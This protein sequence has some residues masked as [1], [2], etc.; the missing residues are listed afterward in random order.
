METKFWTEDSHK[1]LETATDMPRYNR[2]LVSHFVDYFGKNI[3]EVGSGL[4]GLSQYL[5][6]SA[7]I[8]LSDIRDDYFGF[9]KKKFLKIVIKLDIEKNIPKSLAGNFDTI[10]SSNVF[11]HI[12]DDE[13]AFGNA[14]LLLEKGGKLLLFVPAGQKIYGGLDVDMGHY[15]RYTKEDLVNKAK[16]AGFKIID[17]YYTNFIGYFLWWG[18]GKLIGNKIKDPGKSSKMDAL[19]SGFVDF[20]VVPVLYLEKII[21]PP[22]GQSLVLIAEKTN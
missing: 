3:L 20:I 5:P 11:E 9:L 12:K 4:G 21:H 17:C 18:R 19:F 1:I 16:L 2:W 15:R 13:S 10:F 22:L 14:N 6:Q 7:D 8:T